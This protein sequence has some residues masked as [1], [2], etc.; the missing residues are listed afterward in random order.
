MVVEKNAAQMKGGGVV[1]VH[2]NYRALYQMRSLS[3]LYEQAG[4]LK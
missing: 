1:K 4:L 3:T 2:F